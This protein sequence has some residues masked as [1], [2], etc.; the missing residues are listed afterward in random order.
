MA[1]IP[2]SDKVAQFIGQIEIKV[3]NPYVTPFTVEAQ[4]I[5]A[6]LASLHCEALWLP[7][8]ID[9]DSEYQQVCQ[10]KQLP[11]I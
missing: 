10:K 3:V 11:P 4:F 1:F 8:C 9:C 2:L 7:G 5:C 6:D